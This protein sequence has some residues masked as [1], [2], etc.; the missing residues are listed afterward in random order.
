MTSALLILWLN[1]FSREADTSSKASYDISIPATMLLVDE[2]VDSCRLKA[3]CNFV[4]FPSLS[5][6]LFKNTGDDLS[7]EQSSVELPMKLISLSDCSKSFW[8]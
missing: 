5:S 3:P 2:T 4:E 8:G 6:S 7:S 1:Y